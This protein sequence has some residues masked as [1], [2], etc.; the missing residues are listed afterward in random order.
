MTGARP[1]ALLV[2]VV[3]VEVGLAAALG[4]VAVDRALLPVAGIVLAAGL[5]LGLLRHRGRPLV[6]AAG[7]ALAW[8]VR[9]RHRAP[10]PAGA[11][12]ERAGPD[13][14]LRLLRLVVGD[15]RLD[16]RRDHDDRPVGLVGHDGVWCAVLVPDP[17]GSPL[18]T[19]PDEPGFP[20]DA[21]A[22][23]LDDRGVVLDALTA[24]W[25]V[26]P[27]DDGS[28]AGAAGAE[29]RG[30]VPAPARR[31]ALLVVR[32]DPARCPD[33][34][35]ERGG[36]VVG[37]QR[38]LLGALARLRRVLA[39]HGV[40]ARALDD[41]ELAA[42]AVDTGLAG[43]GRPRTAVERWGAA[44]LA[45]DRAACG[46][47]TWAV[48]GGAPDDVDLL[49]AAPL[50]AGVTLTLGVTVGPAPAPGGTGDPVAVRVAV[51]VGAATPEELDAAAAVLVDTAARAGLRPR[52]LDG[53]QTAGLAAT[54]PVAD[55]PRAM[56]RGA[57]D[58]GGH[59]VPARAVD[60]GDLADVGPPVDPAGV[61]LGAGSDGRPVMLA[62][63]RPAPTRVA[64]V[65]GLSLT[66]QL[67][68]RAVAAGTRLVVVTGRPDAWTAL[69]RAA[70]DLVTVRTTADRRPDDRDDPPGAGPLLT[71]HDRGVPPPGADPGPTGPWRTTLVAL[72]AL[73]PD[74]ADLADPAGDTDLVLLTRTPPHEAELAAR[75]WRLPPDLAT[76]LRT[77]PDAGVVALSDGTWRRL[78]RVTGPRETALLGPVR[79][80]D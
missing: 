40:P 26:R 8:R 47:A 31:D 70:P 6:A 51:R 71:V 35:A 16:R 65:G 38:A 23:E 52:R 25:H 80:G 57:V 61:L 17:A 56:T 15:L 45:G 37:A 64:V 72:P 30:D 12:P 48:T 77:L 1:G 34:V 54:L 36:G 68:L 21:L 5:L 44:V 76:A 50:P 7:D 69:R 75:L 3:T 9:V 11:D 60:R 49:A 22:A 27:G 13:D 2:P 63:L 79:R 19:A 32:L 29:V 78:D 43:L 41:R 20:L 14:D 10:E 46:Q 4:L 28:A 39:D 55:R 42:A 24:L 67:A 33:A 62:L 74:V 18:L 66:R 58:P 53:R 73:T 59:P